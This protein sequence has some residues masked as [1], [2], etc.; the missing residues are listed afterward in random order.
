MSDPI[1]AS[2]AYCVPEP[3]VK[4]TLSLCKHSPTSNVCITTSVMLANYN[5]HDPVLCGEG[6]KKEMILANSC[7]CVCNV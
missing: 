4:L 5:P 3:R 7:M 6:G 2:L 1:I